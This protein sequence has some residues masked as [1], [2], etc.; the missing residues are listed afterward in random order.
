MSD[1]RRNI[2]LPEGPL[3][4]LPF[5]E[6]VVFPNTVVTAP[7]G[8]KKSVELI[9]SLSP[10]DR[11]II[12]LQRDAKTRDPSLADLLPVAVLARLH[13]LERVR[14]GHFQATF[15]GIT[16]VALGDLV[17]S[18]PFWRVL[19][20]PHEEPETETDPTELRAL[21]ELLVEQLEEVEPA[22]SKELKLRR[23]KTLKPAGDV[24][25]IVAASLGLPSDREAQVLLAVEPG[26]RLRLVHR[27]LAEAKVLAD[28]KQSIA[29][30]MQGEMGR[31]Q[32]EM[33]LRQQL[34]AIQKELGEGEDGDELDALRTR[35]E[36]AGLPEEAQVAVDRELGRLSRMAPS[37]AEHQVIR[38]YLELIADLPWSARAEVNED[39][40]DV[41]Q[42]LDADHYGLEEVKKRIL[43]HLAVRKMTKSSQGA[44]LSLVGP[45]GVGKTSLGQ[46]IADA[47]GR[48]FVR[49][50]LGGI[51]DEAE[52]RGH[53][54]TYVGALPGRILNAL[55]R[56]GAR[57][58]IVL[59]DEI[60]KLGQG[61]MG[62][63]E[64]AL[65]EVLDP[66]QNHAFTDN[67]LE[68][69]FDLSEVFFIGTANT[70]EGV[71][72]P[73]RDRLEIIELQGYTVEEKGH[74]ARRHLLPEVL[75]KHGLGDA[76]VTLTDKALESIIADYT[77]E[78]GVRQLKRELTRVCRSVTL[79][80]ARNPDR[81]ISVRVDVG[82]LDDY[83][84]KTRFFSD[85]AERT[86]MPGVATGLAWTP[87]GGDVL[88]IET[89]RMPGNGRLEITGKL[90]DVMKE[91]ARAALSYV[92]SHADRLGVDPD[93]R[94]TQD[95]HIHVPAG[96]IPKDGPSA[97]VTIFTA[98]TSLL[99]GRRVHADTAMTGEVTL[100][101]KVLPVGGIKSKILAAH[102]AGLTRIILPE[103][104]GRDLDDLPEEVRNAMEFVLVSDMSEVL[105]AALEDLSASPTPVLDGDN[106]AE[107]RSTDGAL[108]A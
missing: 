47:T 2:A 87:T 94:E 7:V 12:G 78:A 74:I 66:E 28:M 108:G 57:N 90:G 25:D 88:F 23:G 11:L 81:K 18:D 69:P 68:L 13:K 20:R 14:P 52:I 103:R 48:P 85:A 6:G 33:M 35:L 107:T 71:A 70:L 92:R 80:A 1:T 93:V 16:R 39:L 3:P 34:R 64:A 59:L 104:N 97:G 38:T 19:V 43:E 86:A 24:A 22:A 101:G 75:V 72:A 60:D 102:R 83:L 40:D 77:R 44:V 51:R 89:S 105:D 26:E 62:S 31:N 41:A 21:A 106:P 91:S 100:R 37:Q 45:P 58:P 95:L 8:R 73:L 65:L 10:G 49:V 54:R 63:P 56:S 61:W 67:Y 4:L 98:L 50:A 9:Q 99:T 79:E 29:Q 30:E 36:E 15:E 46:S 82:D 32:R 17:S 96:A 76:S 42:Q 5:R 53:R 27:L 55:R 84:G